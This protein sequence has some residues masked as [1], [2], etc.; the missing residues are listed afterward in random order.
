MRLNLYLKE[1]I[2]LLFTKTNNSNFSDVTFHSL[3][4]LLISL[5]FFIFF[6]NLLLGDNITLNKSR[7]FFT[8]KV[9]AY[10]KVVI[11]ELIEKLTNNNC[12]NEIEIAGWYFNN[13]SYTADMGNGKA[14]IPPDLSGSCAVI[15]TMNRTTG[16]NSTTDGNT[17]RAIC[18]GAFGV[19]NN[20][21][22]ND[23][24]AIKFTVTFPA[25]E[26]G[27]LSKLEF[28]QQS[29]TTNHWYP[30]DIDVCNNPA[31]KFGFR[32]LKDGLEIHKSI[33]HLSS[34][35]WQFE[36]FDFTGNTDFEYTNGAVFLFEILAYEKND[37]N[38]WNSI[39]ELEPV[40][41]DLDDVKVFGCCASST[42]SS[43]YC[44]LI[45]D[46]EGDGSTPDTFYTFNHLTGAVTAVGP[47]GTTDVEAMA[48]DTVSQII[49]TASDNDFGTINIATGVFTPLT[50]DMGSLNGAEG[51]NNINDL[52]GMTY[53][54]VNNIIWATERASGVDGLPDDLLLKIDPATG[55]PLPN[56]F[57]AGIGYLTINT[58][59]NDLDD[60]AMATDGTL[61]AISNYG[62]SGNQRLGTINTITGIFTEIG[63]Y[64][65]EDVES[66]TF[67]AT[68][69][70]L[71]TTGKSGEHKNRLY[72]I[73]A[74]TAIATYIGSIEPAH[75]VEA[76]ACNF[77]N[78]SNLQIGDKVWADL[79][80]NGLQTKGEPGVRNVTINLLDG[81]GNPILDDSNN[82]RTTTTDLFG[83]YNFDQ[84]TAGDYQVEFVLPNGGESFT[85]NNVGG[86]DSIDSDANTSTG[87]SAV[88]TLSGSINNLDIDAG[89]LNAN[90]VER[91]C[92]DDGQL[93]VADNNGYILRYDQ[94][95]GALIDTF[96]HGLAGPM[97]M[98]V[99]SDNWLYITN[100]TTGEIR[101]YSPITGALIDIMNDEL[102]E[103]NGMVFGS[104]GFLYLNNR[105]S[106]EVWILDP[107]SGNGTYLIASGT[108]HLDS[109]NGGI[110]FGP[111][112]N[113][114]VASKNTDQVL[115][116]DGTTG[117]FID[118][119]LTA[120]NST[121]N[122]PE[123]LTFGPDGNLYVTSRYTDQVKRYNST[124]GA[125]IDNFVTYQ[126]GGLEDPANLVFGPDGNLYVSSQ[127]NIIGVLRY[128][129]TTGAFMEVFAT[130]ITEPNGFLFAPVPGC[131]N[132][133]CCSQI[134]YANNSLENGTFS[135]FTSSSNPNGTATLTTFGG[136]DAI[137]WDPTGGLETNGSPISSFGANPG[138]WVDASTNGGFGSI[139][140]NRFYWL[141]PRASAA[142]SDCL[143]AKSGDDLLGSFCQ[144]DTVEICGYVAAY[145]PTNINGS[146][147]D[148]DFSFEIYTN[149]GNDPADFITTPTGT[150][151]VNDNGGNSE[152]FTLPLPAST[153]ILDITGVTF[154]GANGQVANWRTL[155]WQLVC[156]QLVLKEDQSNYSSIVFSMADGG[157]GM[158]IDNISLRDISTPNAGKDTTLYSCQGIINL[159][160]ASTG[161]IWSKISEPTGANAVI[162]T[163]TGIVTQLTV[164]GEYKFLLAKQSDVFCHDTIKILVN[165][166]Q[167]ICDNNIDDDGDGLIDDN[168]PDCIGLEF[169]TYNL[170][171]DYNE[172]F[173]I[174]D[175]VH[176]IDPAN[177]IIDWS[178]VYFTYTDVGANDPTNPTD[179]HL[180]DFNN[181]LDVTVTAADAASGTG[182]SGDGRYRIYVVR[183]GKTF[184]DDHMEMRIENG[185][186]NKDD[187]ICIEIC[188]DGLD[189][190]S[191]G[192]IDNTDSDCPIIQ[193]CTC[194]SANTFE[195]PG[196]EIGTFN[197]LDEFLPGVS[198]DNLGSNWNTPVGLDGWSHGPLYWIESPNASEGNRM[199][200]INNQSGGAVCQGQYYDL[201]G[202]PGQ[203]SECAIYQI[204]FD[205]A[206]FNRENPDGRN[207]TSQPALDFTWFDASG[208]TISATHQ[209][210]AVPVANQE[211]DNL[212]W[213]SISFTFTLTGTYAP[214]PNATRVRINISEHNGEDNGLLIDNT[215]LCEV[216][217]CP[218]EIC[219]DG[220]D[221]DGDGLVDCEDPDCQL[222]AITVAVN[223]SIS[224]CPGTEYE[225]NVAFNDLNFINK[226][227]EVIV[228][229]IEGVALMNTNGIFSYISINNDCTSDQFT[230]Q[231]CNP[232]RTCC[233]NAIVY[234]DFV[235]NI[236]PSLQNVPPNDTIGCDELIPL[237]PQIFAV[238][239]CPNISLNV[240][241]E[242][243][244]GED[245]CSLYDYTITRTW[246]A[247]DQC[248]NSVSASQVI[249][250]E[251]LVAPDIYRIYTLPNGTK[252]VAGVMELVGKNW[253]TVNLPI[254]FDA[255]PIIFHQVVTNY[256][257]TPIVSQI[258]NTSVSQFEL[259][260]TEEENNDNIHTRESISW[261]AFEKGT[262]MTDY[263]F[264]VKDVLL[265]S[266]TQMVNFQNAFST[267]PAI[268]TSSQSVFEKDPFSVRYDAL[269]IASVDLNIQ[270]ETS[271]D[272]ETGHINEIIGY[273]ALEEVGDLR[274]EKGVLLGEVGQ[275]TLGSAWSTV[276]LNNT[277]HNPV[278]IANSLSSVDSEPASIRVRNVTADKFEIKVEEWE[279]L[280]G[281]HSNET[282][283]Y[284]V[285]EG[286]IPLMSPG[287]CDL[288][289][290]S[291]D[292]GIDFKAIDNCDVS[293][294]IN[295]T[296]KDT[297]IEATKIITRIWAAEDE[298]GNATAYSQMIEC[299][300]VSLQLKSILQGAMLENNGD[301]L[302]RDDL[303]KKGLIPITEPYSSMINFK[304][305]GLGGGEIMDTTLLL[306]DGAN[307][308]VDWVFVELRDPTDIN[309]V[310]ATCAGLIQCDGDVVTAKGDTIIHF[311]NT[312]IGDYYVAIR[313]RNHLGL[314]ASNTYTFSPSQI[315]FVD[316]TFEF[317]PVEGSNASIEMDNLESLWSGDINSDGRVIYQGP[318]NDV[319]YMF[320]HILQNEGNHDFLPNYISIG[321]T[322]DDFN[323]DGSV[324]YQ[325]PN[326]DRSQ[327]LFHTILTHPDNPERFSNF[328]IYQGN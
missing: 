83:N 316:F 327:L 258:R 41:W 158:V 226:E 208:T 231:I 49:Y 238:D 182:N 95:T 314:I 234:L 46:G 224:L 54:Y 194:S 229:P 73:D 242:S 319:F 273:I 173:N 139:D 248:G 164:N 290:D 101:R 109:N 320:L 27:R 128:N 291:L 96:I 256:D 318:N 210:L 205:W 169:C 134:N 207:T 91:T 176:S 4:R 323:L 283:S 132:V 325:G 14:G 123:D 189:N 286:S 292:I 249:E 174:R 137:D 294:V 62:A 110:E 228:Q 233:T 288:G 114:Y 12:T 297:F 203:M 141:E 279:Y 293:V 179:W 2:V 209:V 245:G 324:I 105:G 64:G 322:N 34:T 180:S 235:D 140:G 301:G 302:M 154:T 80:G 93:L 265:N 126:S 121:L 104:N 328:I 168:D 61:Y 266:M 138:Y 107:I 99:G 112:G 92:A 170:K 252:M 19:N 269:T 51:N 221:N 26:S 161:E 147:V 277:Y 117:I 308:I 255:K 313:H 246:T 237:P 84:L 257:Q 184:Y 190:D 315:P 188:G 143:G 151:Y 193:N 284:M 244:Q 206:S 156:F 57:G 211:W 199:V 160:D 25:S 278:V 129:G 280:N 32:V 6:A 215:N 201:G 116:F 18:I 131:N 304:H 259:R 289:T 70:L 186:S 305:Q 239:N 213:S 60:I 167:E 98:I 3:K 326:N 261:V 187:V 20:W 162:N 125:F 200:Y 77:G 44:Y 181:G 192:L 148:S 251:D 197:G 135:S 282:V 240:K 115:R 202:S 40:M 33:D 24:R 222:G 29:P 311:G 262:Q 136:S 78:F 172:T 298:C 74:A 97:E 296:E 142:G 86:D 119:F 253:K 310:V 236:P 274:D 58:N 15:S 260:I 309:K 38:C 8:V 111:D 250:V 268:F 230:Y 285:I 67:T 264:E 59:E 183:N 30:E 17:G 152:S 94:T 72:S 247:S 10:S 214:P 108:S 118:T 146:S 39:L 5:T 317:T 212:I 166:I 219:T 88:V 47:T 177:P 303:R 150:S 48:Y 153:N 225:G 191:D 75:D 216:I 144:G 163:S 66:L 270:E 82:P 145:D 263:Q 100:E 133:S 157:D 9:K 85:T 217:P 76:C 65:V 31:N 227:F 130:G 185:N 165:C 23:S 254:D 89:L 103:P 113:L 11:K 28:F 220:L 69:Q 52:D 71:A 149:N 102:N 22:D 90:V 276:Y 312:K 37:L 13:Q 171:L 155:N 87:R 55:M 53:D 272:A 175:Y 271:K 35:S 299:E 36:S 306:E 120:A 307:G 243:T 21:V 241:E 218:N 7:S 295:Y 267:V 232:S 196:F 178:Q 122:G 81:S 159:N 321:Y 79:D 300:G 1:S 281:S 63:D 42:N 127:N 106:D 68:G 204:C 16:T 287:Y 45:S 198:A 275:R 43:D 223:D 50:T 56:G 124:T 195:N